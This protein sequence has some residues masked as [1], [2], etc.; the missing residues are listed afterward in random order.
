MISDREPALPVENDVGTDPAMLAYFD[1]AEDQDVVVTG[2]P[3]AKSVVTGN[4]PS[5]GQQVTEGDMAAKFLSHF[6]AQICDERTN[7]ASKIQILAF[8]YRKSRPAH[9]R[10]AP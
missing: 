9:A 10:K 6:A 3:F 4:F 1:I 2:C 7:S 8:S 5:V